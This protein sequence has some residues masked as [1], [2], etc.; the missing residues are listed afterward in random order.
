MLKCDSSLQEEIAQASYT[1]KT[2]DDKRVMIKAGEIHD[3][4]LQSL[5]RANSMFAAR[6]DAEIG[7]H[8]QPILF[9]DLRQIICFRPERKWYSN[10]FSSFIHRCRCEQW[11]E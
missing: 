7:G 5:L 1:L 11:S 6:R 3:S 10:F 2:V 9:L 8:K 4:W